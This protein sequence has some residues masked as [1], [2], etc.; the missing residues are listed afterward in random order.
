MTLGDTEQIEHLAKKTNLV[1]KETAMWLKHLDG[2]RKRRVQGA[3]KA[4]ATRVANNVP[5]VEIQTAED[6]S[7]NG[8]SSFCDESR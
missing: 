8:S 5:V 7:T 2:I 6:Y 3:K 4:A 1:V